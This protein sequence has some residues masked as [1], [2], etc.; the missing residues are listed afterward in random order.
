MYNICLRHLYIYIYSLIYRAIFCFIK[1]ILVFGT[2]FSE[3]KK[4]LREDVQKNK[5][6]DFTNTISVYY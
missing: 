2:I 3:T 1:N 5:V 6:L 4:L